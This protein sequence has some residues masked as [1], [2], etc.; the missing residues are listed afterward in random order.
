MEKASLLE[1]LKN[2][3]Q[4]EDALSVAREVSELR[5]QFED[6]ILEEDRQFQIKQLEAKENGETVEE[7]PFD[8]V[9][10]EFYN[11]HNEFRD[12]KKSL[13]NAKKEAEE[14]NY[15]RKKVLLERMKDVVEKEENIGAA[16][17]AY[18]EIHDAWKEVGD[19]PR[20]KRQDIQSEYSRLL[21]TFF[22][23]IKIYR[24]LR[25][26]DLHRNHQLK[27]DVIQRIQ[28]LSKVENLKDVEQAIK[29]L[30]NE[31]DETGPVG[32][33]AWE[34]LKNSYWDAVR[35]VYTRIQ[36]F[37][38]EKRTELAANLELKKEIA[39]KA[40]EI[41][42][43]FTSTNTKDWD[44]ATATLLALQEEWKKIGFGPRKENEDVW[45]E[46]R[47]AC[48]EFFAKKKTFFDS[49]RGKFD[50]V[51]TKKQQL[52]DRLD[53]MKHS[54]DWKATTDQILSIQKEWKNLGS[55]GQRFEQKLWKDFRAAC[56][57]FFEA[58]QTH[59]SSKDKEF[60]GNLALKMELIE[61]IKTTEIP[62][63]KKEALSLLKTFAT[64]F[65]EIGHVPMKEKDR[66]FNAYKEV[67]DGHYKKL[68]LE[69]AEQEKMLF[70]ARLETLKGDPNSDR[71]LAREKHDL[72]EKI[73]RLKSDILQFENNLGFFAKSKGADLLKKEVESK[74]SAAQRKIEELR[75]KIK[76]IQ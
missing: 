50:E 73:N 4:Q 1:A 38:D 6:V 72:N 53:E 57:H 36:T 67:L 55:A 30:Q 43:D 24:E 59:F 23:H 2:L 25:E 19:I 32:N 5:N 27:L 66:V 26:H 28:E 56:D 18:K 34:S 17:T 69:G 14:A 68:K 51:A 45:K 71:A 29:S 42:T 70:Q 60:E 7:R 44:T 15:R 75:A 10:E 58:K 13:Q 22:Y 9:R 12:R 54:T 47:A 62:E 35:A 39:K 37:Y 63:D 20:E 8:T 76:M 40:I 33:D 31:W 64:E 61:R 52:V 11:L 21:E 16:M 65:N 3:V 46:F 74:I 49:I 48:D 41:V